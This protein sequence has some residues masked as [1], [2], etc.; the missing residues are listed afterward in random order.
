MVNVQKPEFDFLNVKNLNVENPNVNILNFNN[1]NVE[2]PNVNIPNAKIPKILN[3]ENPNVNILKRQN[4]RSIA[5][6]G[7]RGAALVPTPRIEF[8]ALGR[9]EHNF[10]G[11]KSL[12]QLFSDL[13]I[14]PRL[15]F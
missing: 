13:Q 12:L 1:L 9:V 7:R 3:V 14:L 4:R 15:F 5:L 11:R 2:N 10:G 6:D 8:S